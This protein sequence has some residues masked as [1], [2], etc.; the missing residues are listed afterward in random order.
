MNLVSDVESNY[1]SFH[2]LYEKQCICPDS[3]C[4]DLVH[5]PAVYIYMY[6]HIRRR[7]QS[8][9]RRFVEAV[10]SLTQICPIVGWR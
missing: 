5:A 8:G 9:V 7:E 4:D 6:T 3:Q 1:L 10:P 2:N